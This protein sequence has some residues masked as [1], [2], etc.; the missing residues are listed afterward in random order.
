MVVA[1]VFAG[2]LLI[3]VVCRIKIR[4]KSIIKIHING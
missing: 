3:V 2:C 4:I 1:V